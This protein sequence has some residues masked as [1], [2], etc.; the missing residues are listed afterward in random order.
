MYATTCV[1]LKTKWKKLVTRNNKV[2]DSIY[3]K[4]Q[5][6]TDMQITETQ[7]KLSI[8]IT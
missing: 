5:T 1:N 8:V 3:I 6:H 4:Q 7:S 2:Y